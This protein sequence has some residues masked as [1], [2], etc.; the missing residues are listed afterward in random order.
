MLVVRNMSALR[1]ALIYGFAGTAWIILSDLVLYGANPGLR[2]SWAKGTLF[3]VV[4]ASLMYVLTSRLQR[5]LEAQATEAKRNEAQFRRVVDASPVGTFVQTAGVL[6]Y[7]NPA[8]L[9]EFGAEHASELVGRAVFDVVHPESADALQQQMHFVVNL[10]VSASA[11]RHVFRHT[12]GR[13]FEVE[14]SAVPILYDGHPGALVFFQNVTERNNRERSFQL[15]ADAVP[16]VVCVIDAAGYVTY[17]NA[18]WREFTGEGMSTASTA[19][20]VKSLH[21]DDIPRLREAWQQSNAGCTAFEA[22]FRFRRG[23]GEYRWHVGRALPMRDISGEL[24][25]WF[26]VALDIDESMRFKVRMQQ[27]LEQERARIARDLHDDLGQ[28]LTVAKL[29]IEAVPASGEMSRAAEAVSAAMVRTRDLAIMLRPPVIDKFGLF[30]ALQWQ[31]AEF[32]R[33]TRIQC[34]VYGT[35]GPE[36]EFAPDQRI[37]AFRI[38]QEALN[39]VSRHSHATEVAIEADYDDQRLQIAV[40]DNGVGMDTSVQKRSGLG[41]IGM[42]E[43][44]VL[45]NASVEIESS[46]KLGTVVRLSMRLHPHTKA[47]AV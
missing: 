16:A 14:V 1:I 2:E 17:L 37:A 12:D 36:P 24:V 22:T 44:A 3:I 29:C 42:Q 18:R 27:S 10:G 15:M 5:Q 9:T 34:D 7:A 39:N 46:R 13:S 4:T 47:A 45:A 33:T 8:A 38:V 40:R 41:I 35:D 32:Q 20:V 43:R 26:G 28:L 21:P 23:D 25:K 11:T 6:R 31:A 19:S 30:G